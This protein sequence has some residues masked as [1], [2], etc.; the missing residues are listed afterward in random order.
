MEQ[1]INKPGNS[2]IGRKWYND[3]HNNVFCFPGEEPHSYIIGMLRKNNAE[4]KI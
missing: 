4:E 2:C 1:K 3:G